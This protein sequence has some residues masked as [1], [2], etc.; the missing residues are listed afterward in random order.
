M[1]DNRKVSNT[2]D[3]VRLPPLLKKG[4]GKLA[5]IVMTDPDLSIEAK[6]IYAYFVSHASSDGVTYPSRDKILADTGIGINRFYRHFNTIKS[7]DWDAAGKVKLK[8]VTRL[9]TVSRSEDNDHGHWQHNIYTLELLPDSYAYCDYSGRS[10]AWHRSI[11]LVR[12]LKSIY[13][14][15]YGTVPCIVMDDTTLSLQARAVYAYLCTFDSR[16]SMAH[17]EKDIMMYHLGVS[18]GSFEKYIKE[19]IAHN[20]VKSIRE[21]VTSPS[22]YILIEDPSAPDYGSAPLLK[23]SDTV[24]KANKYANNEYS[25]A[26]INENSTSLLKNSDTVI[27]D[28]AIGDM[29]SGDSVNENIIKTV[30]PK[31]EFNNTESYLSINS[32]SAPVRDISVF[33][34]GMIDR[35]SD[36]FLDLVASSGEI[37]FSVSTQAESC[38]LAVR[39]LTGWN[40]WSS[41]FSYSGPTAGAERRLYLLFASALSEMICDAYSPTLIRKRR[42]TAAAVIDALNAVLNAGYDDEGDPFADLGNLRAGSI[43]RFVEFKSNNEVYNDAGLMK[44]MIWTEL[45]SIDV[46]SVAGIDTSKNAPT[47]PDINELMTI[48]DKI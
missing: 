1:S 47:G 16:H 36:S 33:V 26:Y 41:K 19:L 11:A 14:A 30:L 32:S 12:K 13:A 22:K 46:S 34:D 18:R 45:N 9:I 48:L 21:S 23:N 31:T 4:F 40:T 17:P 25:S 27:S 6:G 28:T 35:Q 24:H 43:R 38:E 5:K 20:Y 10:D 29:V 3:E 42:I 37:P 2:A 7:G 44:A 8:D 15:G 39:I